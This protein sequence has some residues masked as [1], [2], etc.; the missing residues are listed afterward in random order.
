M[1]AMAGI[2]QLERGRPVSLQELSWRADW[3]RLQTIELTEIAGSGHY[4][5]T[6]SCAEMLAVLYYHALRLRPGEPAWAG[7][8]PAPPR[9]GPRAPIG[10]YPCLADLGDASRGRGSPT[11][12]ASAVR[13]ATTPT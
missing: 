11:T 10:V 9:Q 5:S 2:E 4:A 6:F 12:P 8:R 13:S 3:I 1:L 7:P